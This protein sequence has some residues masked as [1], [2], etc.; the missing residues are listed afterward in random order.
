MLAHPMRNNANMDTGLAS[1]LASEAVVSRGLLTHHPLLL[2]LFLLAGCSAR[3]TQAPTQSASS[4]RPT[5]TQWACSTRQ[6]ECDALALA[7]EQHRCLLTYSAWLLHVTCALGD[8]LH[9][10]HV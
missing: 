8:C 3:L 10:L 4:R 7:R 2:L 6:R 5:S 9:P 1:V